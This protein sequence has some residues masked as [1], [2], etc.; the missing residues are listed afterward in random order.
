MC[1]CLLGAGI[2]CQQGAAYG[3]E[4]AQHRRPDVQP[5]LTHHDRDSLAQSDADR[6]A[7]DEEADIMSKS[8][9]LAYGN[10]QFSEAERLWRRALE[11]RVRSSERAATWSNV[12]SAAAAQGRWTDADEAYTN[13]LTEAAADSVIASNTLN[14]RAGLYRKTGRLVEAEEAARSALRMAENIK[15]QVAIA[16]RAHTLATILAERGQ[17]EDALMFLRRSR[18]LKTAA[19][20]ASHPDM[21][22]TASVTAQ[23]LLL[24]GRRAEAEGFTNES[25]AIARRNNGAAEIPIASSLS[26]LAS[27]YSVNGRRAEADGIHREVIGILDAKLGKHHPDS[28]RARVDFAGYLRV[29]GRHQAAIVMYTEALRVYEQAFGEGSPRVIAI[30]SALATSRKAVRRSQGAWVLHRAEVDKAR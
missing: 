19:G 30:Q 13:A 16:S 27:I 8:A 6:K 3:S 22:A 10:A 23:V 7:G 24:M 9:A 12:G 15:D 5:V 25:L 11:N 20:L 18:E 29:I 28:A 14:N 26:V 4:T 21:G 2:T 1:I 17:L